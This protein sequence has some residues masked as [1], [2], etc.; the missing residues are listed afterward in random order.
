MM[1]PGFYVVRM[2]EDW[3]DFIQVEHPKTMCS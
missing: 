3:R 2:A 1:H